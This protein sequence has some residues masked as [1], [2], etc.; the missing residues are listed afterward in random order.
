MVKFSA[1]FDSKNIENKL[2]IFSSSLGGIFKELMKSVGQEMVADTKA[3]A[4]F[5][6]R[7]GKL[8]NAITFIPTDNGG[9]LTTRKNLNKSNVYYARFVEGGADIKAKKG[10]YLTFK[11]NGEWKKVPSVK[12]RPRPFM[13]PVFDEYWESDNGK[14]YKALSDSLQKKMVDYLKCHFNRNKRF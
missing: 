2:R 7:T 13:N 12:V 1:D 3:R 10:K 4:S 5:T 9:V 11:I 6:N 14:G 8:F